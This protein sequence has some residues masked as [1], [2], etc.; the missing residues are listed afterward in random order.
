[1]AQAEEPD[2]SQITETLSL[3]SISPIPEFS[4]GR[5]FPRQ[6]VRRGRNKG[7]KRGIP[8]LPQKQAFPLSPYKSYDLSVNMML[9]RFPRSSV[10]AVQH[11]HKVI[12]PPE[13][14][15]FFSLKSEDIQKLSLAFFENLKARWGFR[16]L[17]VIWRCRRCKKINDEDPMTLEK[18]KEPVELYDL[19]N[20][21]IYTFEAKSLARAWK[22]NLLSHDGIFPEPK[23]PLNPFT[24][25]PLP[26]FH[27]HIALKTIRKLGYIDWVLDSFSES[28]YNLESWNKK[29]GTPLKIESLASI[30]CDKSS[31]DRFDILMDF[32]ELQFDYHGFDF[33]KKM[34]QWIFLKHQVE[35]YVDAWLCACKKYYLEKY[36]LSEKE[37]LDEL[38][39]RSSVINAYLVEVPV[40]VKVL[41]T[42][43][44]EK[45]SDNGRRRVQNRIIRGHGHSNL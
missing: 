41:Y 14:P 30:L 43:Y 11:F 12:V 3:V 26:L 29:F 28:Q 40:I 1:M 13:K 42:K 17:S 39:I 22:S 21:A 16:K 4:M 44:V 2:I 18:I 6:R 35:E 5:V 7:V 31:Y 45:S 19:Y 24:N 36:T 10:Q 34:F 33:P 38:D 20:K 27:I 37:D 15:N 25:L 8:Y 32:A 23:F 9:G